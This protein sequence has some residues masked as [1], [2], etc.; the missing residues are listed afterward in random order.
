MKTEHKTGAHI[1]IE[2]KTGAYI[3]MEYIYNG[4]Y[5]SLKNGN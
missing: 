5:A 4:R 1:A 2:H 3:P